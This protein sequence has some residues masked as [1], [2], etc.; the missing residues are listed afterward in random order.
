MASISEATIIIEASDISGSLIQAN[1]CCKLGK[2]LFILDSC[3]KNPKFT[4]P[5]K[6]E[7]K[8]AIRVKNSSEI[9]NHLK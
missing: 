4:W 3:F 6:Y 7:R 9:L 2:K 1:K 8:G 5:A